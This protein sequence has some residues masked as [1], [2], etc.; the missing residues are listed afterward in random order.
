MAKGTLQMKKILFCVVFIVVFVGLLSMIPK[1]AKPTIKTVAGVPAPSMTQTVGEDVIEINGMKVRIEKKYEYEATGITKMVKI[2]TG[3]GF[4]DQVSPMDIGLLWG[5]AAQYNDKLTYDWFYEGRNVLYTVYTKEDVDDVDFDQ[6]IKETIFG[7]LIPKDDFVRAEIKK[8]KM[9]QYVKIKGY[10]V[11]AYFPKEAGAGI[12]GF[13][14]D[15][16]D[17]HVIY[18]T[19]V[20][21]LK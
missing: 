7:R 8:I 18:V 15:V 19:G 6:V 5:S 3:G 1:L 13:A 12:T 9:N 4:L 21:W 10:L 14:T 20:E 16:E 11:N 17:C 2:Y